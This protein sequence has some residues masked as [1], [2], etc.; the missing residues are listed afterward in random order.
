MRINR[1]AVRV[2][3]GCCH[4]AFRFAARVVDDHP[5]AGREIDRLIEVAA[6]E[7]GAITQ[8]PIM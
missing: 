7:N 1:A 6:V 8:L 3:D 4:Q 2:A 5:A